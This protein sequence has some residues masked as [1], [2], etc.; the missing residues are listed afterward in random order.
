[1]R[2]LKRDVPPR[3]VWALE[4]AGVHPLLAQ[5]FAARGVTHPQELD[6][7]LQHLLPWSRKGTPQEAA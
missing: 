5:L 4:Q 3:S 2:C 7:Q 6:P 1:M